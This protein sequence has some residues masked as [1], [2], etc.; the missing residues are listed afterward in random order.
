MRR[1]DGALAVDQYEGRFGAA[2]IDAE[3]HA[4]TPSE[5]VNRDAANDATHGS[6]AARL[7][8]RVAEQ[9]RAM[10]RIELR[11]HD[12]RKHAPTS[13]PASSSIFRVSVSGGVSFDV[14]S[15]ITRVARPSARS[16]SSRSRS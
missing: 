9:H 15:A 10:K 13:L 11:A 1:V 12:E 8:G 7:I 6:R 16:S 14:V 5:R 4:I 2:T 3:E